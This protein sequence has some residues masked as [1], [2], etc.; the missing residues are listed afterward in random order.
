MMTLNDLLLKLWYIQNIVVIES[1]K[2]DI[3]KDSADLSRI[4]DQALFSG[5]LNKIQSVN[6]SHLLSRLV[7]S[8]G[9]IDNVFIIIIHN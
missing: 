1:D 6:N 4:K 3:V 8:Y 2:F 7:K 9:V 5:P